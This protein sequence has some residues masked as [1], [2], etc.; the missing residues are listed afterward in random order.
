MYIHVDTYLCIHIMYVGMYVYYVCMDVCVCFNIANSCY[1]F[2]TYVA[3]EPKGLY[4][5]Y[6][7]NT[8]NPSHR[9]FRVTTV[10]SAFTAIQICLESRP[11]S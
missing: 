5:H 4:R 3:H 6:S 2:T 10:C 8:L 9:P 11:T 7:N 1:V